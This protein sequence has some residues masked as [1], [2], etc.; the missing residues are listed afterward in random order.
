MIFVVSGPSGCGKST[1]IGRVLDRRRD[2]RFSVSHTTRPRRKGERDGRE[3]HFVTPP[4]FER[5]AARGRFAEWAVVHGRL[6]GTSKAEIASKG[7]GGDLVLDVDIQG[8]RSIRALYEDAVTVFVLP[9]RYAELRRRL[10]ARGL[11]APDAIRTRLANARREIGHY[12]EF[13]YLVIND[14]L[15]RAAAEL[16]AVVVGQRC[17]REARERAVAPILRS[18]RTAPARGR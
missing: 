18:F 2:L 14:D 11:D 5:M 8:A 13:E 10:R 15:E 6:Y 16:E 7:R 12:R 17:R 9:P 4:A 1:L 3:Y